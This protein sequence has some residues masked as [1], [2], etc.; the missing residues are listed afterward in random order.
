MAKFLENVLLLTMALA[1]RGAGLFLAIRC[2]PGKMEEEEEG[3]D[4]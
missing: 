2:D 1:G 4:A 3:L